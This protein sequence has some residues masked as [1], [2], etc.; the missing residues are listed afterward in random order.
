VSGRREA[1]DADYRDAK[2]PVSQ[3]FICHVHS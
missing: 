2:R 3:R 1:K